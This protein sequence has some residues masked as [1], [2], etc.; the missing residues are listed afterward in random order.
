MFNLTFELLST[1]MQLM[2]LVVG[3]VCWAIG[4]SLL[5]YATYVR[6]RESVYQGEVVA[7]RK[8]G[9]NEYWPVLAYTDTKGA[10]HEALANSGSSQ[11][12]GRVPGT[13]VRLLAN[14]ASPDSPMML[15]DWWGLV[16]IGV[17]PL[18]VGYPFIHAGLRDLHFD[19]ITIG[20][21]AAIAAWI[22]QKLFRFVHPLLD[23][24]KSGAAMLAQ[25]AFMQAKQQS[26]EALPL[27]SAGDVA[28]V[29][30][31]QSRQMA[32]ARPYLTAIG[33]ALFLGGGFW[34]AH[35]SIFLSQAVS[36]P[37]VVIRNDVSEGGGNSSD[38]FHAV[39]RF[40][41]ED[42]RTVLYRDSVGTSP[43]WYR[44]GDRVGVL[45]LPNKPSRIMI[46]R[47]VWNWLVQL[48]LVVLGALLFITGAVHYLHNQDT[49][50]P[51][52]QPK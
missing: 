41:G 7:V 28:T 36:A 21:G 5:G 11:I 38:S 50:I 14:P 6:V 49:S 22:A 16:V 46:D 8:D 45:Y 9:C 48:A 24:R 12:S 18:G 17:F 10:R 4:L 3:S 40:T 1:Y 42:G 26:R 30:A 47:G 31:T 29:Q 33:L 2:Y 39:V 34:L 35:Q 19:W 37:G 15:R 44:E 27:V 52:P 25:R 23:A 43:P 51:Q 20:V 13:R 32:S